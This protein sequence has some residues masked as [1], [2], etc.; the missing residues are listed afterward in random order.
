MALQTASSGR[1][2]T[3][4]SS[5]PQTKPTGSPRRS[6]PRSALLRIPP[7]RRAQDVKLGFAHCALETEQQAII[8]HRRM[9]EAIC[10]ADERVGE[11]AEIKQAVPICIVAGEAGHFESEHDADMSKRDFCGETGEAGA[12]DDTGAG[13]AEVFVDHDDPV[14]WP[15]KRGCLGDQSI[16]TLRRFAIVLDLSGG[17]LSK[18]DVSRAAQLRRT[19]LCD[20]THRLPPSHWRVERLLR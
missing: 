13:Q 16:L 10:I 11:T 6:S 7:L 8:E 9:I 15:A 1:N 12:L 5:S 2:R 4:P 3:S 19:D 20:V 17:G 14:A 18:I